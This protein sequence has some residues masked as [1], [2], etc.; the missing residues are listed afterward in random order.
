MFLPD[1][2]EALGRIR[3]SLKPGAKFATA[4]WGT[5]D[6]VPFIS[7]PFGI[8]QKVLQPPPPPPPPDAPN[9]FKLGGPGL[10]DSAL[11]QAGFRNVQSSVLTVQ[12]DVGSPEE[13]RD[14]MRGIAPPIRALV[15]ERGAAVQEAF[16]EAVLEGARG[17]ADADGSIRIPNDAILAVGGK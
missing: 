13:Y 16:W 17:F 14:F 7:M 11:E 8:A 4:V 6:K 9:L 10:I 1:L 3:R 5:P 2:G 12:L 15:S